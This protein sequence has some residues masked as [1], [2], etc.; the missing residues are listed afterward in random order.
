MDLKP[1]KF[2]ILESCAESISQELIK[3]EMIMHSLNLMSDDVDIS[4][5]PYA[6]CIQSNQAVLQYVLDNL[7]QICSELTSEES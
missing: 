2:L 4:L 5:L 3:S 6:V 7:S 1:H